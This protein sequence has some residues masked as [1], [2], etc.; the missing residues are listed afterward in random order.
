MISRVSWVRKI[1]VTYDME[2]I[3]EYLED[4]FVENPDEVDLFSRE[5]M[6]NN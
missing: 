4:T 2:T 3:H 5:I 6:R 1:Q